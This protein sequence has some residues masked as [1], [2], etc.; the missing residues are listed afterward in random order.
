[1]LC[2][3]MSGC[4]T[5]IFHGS[6]ATWMELG[7]FSF[8]V[9]GLHHL[10]VLRENSCWLLKVGAAG[11][12]LWLLTQRYSQKKGSSPHNQKPQLSECMAF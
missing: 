2:A 5:G 4:T 3:I 10:P 7:N 9:N 8:L 11:S 1:M 12:F 6:G